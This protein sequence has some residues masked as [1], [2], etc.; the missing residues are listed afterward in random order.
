MGQLV[1]P[2][3]GSYVDMFDDDDSVLGP[4]EHPAYAG[5]RTRDGRA[6]AWAEYGSARG[7]PC[8]LIPDAGSSRLSPSWLLLDSALPSSIRLLALDRP[9]VGHSDPVGLGGMDDPADDLRA[10]VQ[11]LAVGRVAVI[12]IGDGADDAIGFAERHPQLVA[13][14][15]MVSPRLPQP[16]APRRGLRVR[17][18]D[19]SGTGP[20]SAVTGWAQAVGTDL[21][22]APAW[23]S[24]LSRMS[25]PLRALLGDRFQEEDFRAA[26]AA[27]AAE[28]GNEWNGTTRAPA[29]QH[30]SAERPAAGTPVR[31]WHGQQEVTPLPVVR[32]TA[33]RCGW[34]LS[35]VASPSA[36]LGCWP[37][38]LTTAAASFAATPAA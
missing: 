3:A 17:R 37:Q 34:Q 12:G 30:W 16:T 20:Q 19:R 9:G 24:G 35:T 29:A 13:G 2:T 28:S 32:E 22:S 31:V 11:T 6:L 36:V 27:D 15:S 38:I 5:I 26:V 4:V 7:V 10:L 33:T 8:V 18:R 1:L 21:H 25:E 23:E 14:V